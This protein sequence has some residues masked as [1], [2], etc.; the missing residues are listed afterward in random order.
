[1]ANRYIELKAKDYVSS[2]DLRMTSN[3]YGQPIWGAN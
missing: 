2:A 1:M 3:S